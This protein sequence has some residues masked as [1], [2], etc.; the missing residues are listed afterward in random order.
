[1]DSLVVPA[2]SVLIAPNGRAAVTFSAVHGPLDGE[3]V[4]SLSFSAAPVGAVA[5]GLVGAE[6]TLGLTPVSPG[7]APA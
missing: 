1:M 3:V 7:F 4:L 5:D 2:A 6:P